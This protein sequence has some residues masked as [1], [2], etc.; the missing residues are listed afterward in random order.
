[1]CEACL[2]WLQ[3]RRS[4]HLHTRIRGLQWVQ[5][6]SPSWW[7]QKH[8][9]LLRLCSWKW[10]PFGDQCGLPPWLNSKESVCSAGAE[11]DAGSIPGLRRPFGGGNGNTLWYSC[12]ENPKDRGAW[13][14]TVCEVAKS[15]TQLKRLSIQARGTSGQHIS[16]VQEWGWG[17]S[18]CPG[19][20]PGSARCHALLMTSTN[21]LLESYPG[22]CVPDESGW[23]L[24]WLLFPWGQLSIFTWIPRPW[25]LILWPSPASMDSNLSEACHL[26]DQNLCIL[27]ESRS[28]PLN[29]AS[30]TSQEYPHLLTG[31][32]HASSPSPLRLFSLFLC[33]RS[34]A[35]N[36]F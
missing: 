18:H 34:P 6:H 23:L 7:S 16:Q 29:L 30:T 19:S 14:V 3:D 8:I 10:F 25:P 36:Y 35:E 28:P 5:S 31:S 4:L 1:M 13:Q 17:T 27:S 33:S 15:W 21:R 20:V 32:T 2:E 26:G 22:C 12:L 11:G 9:S 24:Y